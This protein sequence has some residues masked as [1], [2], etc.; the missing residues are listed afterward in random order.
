MCVFSVRVQNDVQT[1][2]Q[3]MA[4]DGAGG[5]E[6]RVITLKYCEGALRLAGAGRMQNRISH[7]VCL[8]TTDGLLDVDEDLA[9]TSASFGDELALCGA[10]RHR[11]GMP[12]VH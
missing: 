2:A 8:C 12:H 1:W 9:G 5:S 11:A 10:P 6:H 3:F 7:V 4:V